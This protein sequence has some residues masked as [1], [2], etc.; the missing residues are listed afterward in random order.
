MNIGLFIGRFQPFHKGH[1]ETLKFALGN[2]DQLIIAIGSAQKSHEPRNPFTAGE[3]VLM[4][5][6]S[7]DEDPEVDYNKILIIPVP[8]V[9]VHKLWTYQ[10]D[11]LVPSYNQVY[12]N[13]EFTKLLFWERGMKVIE[14]KLYNRDQYSATEVRKRIV[15]NKDWE[16]LVTISTSKIIKQINGIERVKSIYKEMQYH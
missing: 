4:I 6:N 13:D 16:S 9:N 3:R 5:R 1:L 8:D 12:S 14:P 11:M 15:T 2:V 7:I 10:L